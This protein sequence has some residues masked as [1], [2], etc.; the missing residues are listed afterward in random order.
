MKKKQPK[1]S[2]TIRR[3]AER[4][5]DALGRDR[6]RLFAASTG[7]SAAHPVLVE[8]ASVVEARARAVPCPRCEGEHAVVE[9]ASINGPFGRLR[10]AK[11]RCRRCAS[12]RSM[13]FRLP[14][15]N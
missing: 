12:T 2:R 6:E 10:E 4:R 7:G 1:R 3:E 8:S 9:H 11:L 15:L 5:A 13:F 14:V